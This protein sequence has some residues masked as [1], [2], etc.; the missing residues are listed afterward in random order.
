MFSDR[1]VCRRSG[2]K[3]DGKASGERRY[4]GFSKQTFQKIKQFHQIIK[5]NFKDRANASNYLCHVR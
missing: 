5:G 3:E 2:D 1:R 4:D